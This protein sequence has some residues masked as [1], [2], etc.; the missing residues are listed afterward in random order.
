VAA[1]GEAGVAE[2]AAL[3]AGGAPFLGA[4]AVAGAALPPGGTA[5]ASRWAANG[6]PRINAAAI[7]TSVLLT[8]IEEPLF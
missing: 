8:R 4:G 7:P 2:A 6:S 1:G 3:A 5:R